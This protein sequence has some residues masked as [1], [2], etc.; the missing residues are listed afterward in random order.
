M[1]WEA[2]FSDLFGLGNTDI[3][4]KQVMCSEEP[5]YGAECRIIPLESNGKICATPVDNMRNSSNTPVATA[6]DYM[7]QSKMVRTASYFRQ[8]GFSITV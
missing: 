5:N 3:S 7:R 2:F 8:P 6:V 1:E 4:R